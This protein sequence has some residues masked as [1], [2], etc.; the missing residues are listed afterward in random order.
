MMET[1]GL[2]QLHHWAWCAGGFA[3]GLFFGF[4]TMALCAIRHRSEERA[5]EARYHRWHAAH[6]QEQERIKH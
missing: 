5:I 3:I 6:H 4:F 2:L 1:N